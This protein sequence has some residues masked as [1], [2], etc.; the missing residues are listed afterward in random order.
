MKTIAPQ[1]EPVRPI[2]VKRKPEPANMTKAEQALRQAL[3]QSA[4]SHIGRLA[5]SM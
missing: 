2:K 3:K 1:Q 4:Q 5:R